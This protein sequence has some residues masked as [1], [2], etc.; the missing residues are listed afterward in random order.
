MSSRKLLA[1]LAALTLC[2]SGALAGEKILT[3]NLGVEPRTIDPVLNNAV[4]GS[5]VDYNVFE[6]L[7]R[8]DENGV[9]APGCAEKWDVSEDGLT[10]TFHLRDGL[11]WSDGS[12]L[13]AADFKFGFLRILIPEN[14]APYGYLAYMIKNGKEFFEGKCKAED[15]GIE[16]PDDKTLVLHMA[17]KSPLVLQYLSFNPFVPAKR[18]LVEAN[19]RGW[20]IASMPMLSNGPFYVAEWKHN[21]EMLLKKNP[22]Y[23][24]AANVKLDG[25]RLLMIVDSNTALAAF[26]AKNVDVN[27]HLPPLMV[28]QLIK[29]GEAKVLPT[30]GTAFTVFNVTKKPFD[31]PRVRKAFSLAIDRKAIVEKVTQGGQHPANG[32]IPEKIPGAVV[33]GPDFRS[34]DS[35]VYLTP[36][37]DVETAKKL[38]A[39]AG[40]PDGKGFPS[41][42]YT[43]NGNPGNKAIAEVLQAMWKKNLGVDVELVQ[44]EWKVF[45]DTRNQKNYQI[46]RHAWIA[47]FNDAQGML[48]LWTSD[49]F[50][51]CTGW[52]NAEY[53]KLIN[54]AVTMTDMA[55]R[56]EDMHKAE[57]ILMDEMPVMPI[58]YYATP[59]LMQPNVKGVYQSPFLWLLFRDAD[60][61]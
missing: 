16:A 5:T 6:G 1:A 17:E 21:S 61:E 12:P 24:D 51:N 46:A 23:W 59:Y 42:S 54:A 43:Y 22:N 31:D 7:V 39:E 26:K 41:V 47:D 44:Q 32:F 27:D 2:A 29:S 19:P 53:D 50:E 57:K 11:K 8:P 55:K 20:T 34:E 10:W 38:L 37:A 4:D 18:E 3:Y 9:I 35:N 49:N 14:A 52:K 28:A 36:N 15:V 58:Y 25:V 56:A 48:A 40:Y 45:I 60:I 13:T 33:G 30:L